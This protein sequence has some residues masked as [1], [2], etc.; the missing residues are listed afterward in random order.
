MWDASFSGSPSFLFLLQEYKLLFEGAG[1]NPGDKTLE[2][3]FFEHEVSRWE[4]P[5]YMQLFHS[6]TKREATPIP[7]GPVVASGRE[8]KGQQPE[9]PSLLCCSSSWDLFLR[10]PFVGCCGDDDEH[11]K[12]A[13]EKYKDVLCCHLQFFRFA[14]GFGQRICGLALS[15]SVPLCHC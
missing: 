6:V 15:P 14:E 9:G 12:V 8:K 13:A 1:S 10:L 3:R 7:H 5:T 11:H 4:L 2:D